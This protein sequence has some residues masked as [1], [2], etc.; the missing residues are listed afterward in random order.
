MGA[1][2]PADAPTFAVGAIC[3]DLLSALLDSW[4]LWEAVAADA[5]RA[6]WGRRW[7]ETALRLVTASG[8]YRPYREF[9][10]TAARDVGL[11]EG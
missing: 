8:D 1:Q 6:G 9:I 10:V 3:F 4:T 5:G 11:D 7:R 2:R